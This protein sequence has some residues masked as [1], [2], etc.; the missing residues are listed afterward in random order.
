MKSKEILPEH[1]RITNECF[2]IDFKD[3]DNSRISNYQL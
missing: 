3:D 1:D 2:A